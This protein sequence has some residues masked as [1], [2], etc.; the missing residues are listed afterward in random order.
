LGREQ[1][2]FSEIKASVFQNPSTACHCIWNP[3]SSLKKK[4]KKR[5]RKRK[6]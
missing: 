1:K 6:V 3:P 2:D 4:N 5:K